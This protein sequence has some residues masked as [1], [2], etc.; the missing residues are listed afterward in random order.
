ML[1]RI[2]PYRVETG[3]GEVDA[4]GDCLNTGN[5]KLIRGD[6]DPDDFNTRGQYSGERKDM[7][8]VGAIYSG[9][10]YTLEAWDYYTQDFVNTFY[11]YGRYTFA[12]FKTD[13]AVSLAAQYGNQQDVG[14]HVAGNIDT[15]FYG[16]KFQI[17]G[18]GLSFFSSYNEVD[19]NEAS[20]DGGT[21]FV[22]WGTPQM[23][24]SF[25]VQDSEL[26]GTRSI[27]AGLQYDFGRQGLLPG[28][29]MR[30]RY[31]L[32]DLPDK[33]T[34]A[35]ARQ[36]RSEATFDL[37]YSFTRDSGFGIFTHMEGLSLQFRLAYNDYQTNYNIAAFKAIHGYDFQSVTDDFIDARI[38]LDYNF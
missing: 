8:L 20:Y 24:N 15:W 10:A 26:A 18:P 30:I 14:D 33:V 2:D 32:Y 6:F 35:D 16:F 21:I 27:G 22:R 9:E 17:D 1:Q 37:R 34:Q 25:Q 7:P 3:C 31:G 28:V 23:F 5:K 38:Y 36:D 13:Y 19:Y 4:N 11:L 29:V 12:P